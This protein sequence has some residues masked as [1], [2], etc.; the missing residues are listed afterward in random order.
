MLTYDRHK[1]RRTRGTNRG[2]RTDD[3]AK[4]VDALESAAKTR[5]R[6]R[7]RGAGRPARRTRRCRGLESMLGVGDDEEGPNWQKVASSAR[8]TTPGPELP[9]RAANTDLEFFVGSLAE[10]KCAGVLRAIGSLGTWSPKWCSARSRVLGCATSGAGTRRRFVHGSGTMTLS[11]A[12]RS[13][14]PPSPPGRRWPVRQRLRKKAPD[15][16]PPGPS[17]RVAYAAARHG[18][19]RSSAT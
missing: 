7:R 19:R 13:W 3:A 1:R 8:T 9:Q 2:G 15:R 11:D 12:R 16:R 17:S 6:A 10:R 4:P 5:P 18:R 14:T